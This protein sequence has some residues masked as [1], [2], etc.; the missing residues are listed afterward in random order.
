MSKLKL[1][2]I[3]EGNRRWAKEKNLPTKE[4]HYQGFKAVKDVV[5]EYLYNHNDKFDTLVVYTFSTENWKRPK[6]EV[7]YL[8]KLLGQAF[9][10][11]NIKKLHQKEIKVQ[12]IG[13]KERLPR[14]L[15]K[16]IKKAEK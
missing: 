12:A 5:F 11:K 9:G 13:Q 16:K 7:S 1:G 4:G 8:I 14:P 2:L 10:K 3:A 6:K 15:Q